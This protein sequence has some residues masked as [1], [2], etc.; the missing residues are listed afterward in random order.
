MAMR[1]SMLTILTLGWACTFSLSCQRAMRGPELRYA[2]AIV[3]LT[4]RLKVE[5]HLGAP[6][7]GETPARD[8]KLR[9]PILILASPVTVQQDTAR[10]KNNITTAGVSEIQL[11]MAAPEEQYLQLVGRVVVAK[12]LLFH[13]FTAH[14]YRDIVM[15]VRKLTVR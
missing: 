11:N 13:A 2:P 10:D 1:A 9:L 3:E 4:G 7:Y 6:G 12:G 8:E 14:H 15:V 5:D